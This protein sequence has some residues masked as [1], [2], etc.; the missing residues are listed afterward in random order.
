M[1]VTGNGATLYVAALGSDKVGVFSTAQLETDTFVPSAASQIPV[2][3]GGPTGL[4]L[5]EDRRQLYVMTRFDN[6]ISIVDTGTRAETAHVQMH[7]PEPPSIVAGRRFLYD[8]KFSSSHGD[9]S[10]ASCHVFGDFD[11]LAWDLG[12]PDGK[13]ID[14]PGPF[15]SA[16]P[17]PGHG[18]AHGAHLPPDEGPDGD[19]E[20][21]RHGQPRPDALARRPHRRQRRAERPAGQRDLRRARGV[22]QVQRGVPRSARAPRGPSRKRR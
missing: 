13:V 4:V 18:A 20:P 19:A 15:N 7:N 9:S 1:A 3:G 2:S 16:P 22:R 10:C 21:A 11:S 14:N 12:N 6:G 8:A 17:Q 5:D